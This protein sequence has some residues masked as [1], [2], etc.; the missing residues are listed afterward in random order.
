[1]KIC[2][3]G[4]G[5][6][7]FV[8]ALIL[9]KSYPQFTVDVIRS[10]KIGTIGVGEGSTEHWQAFMD[11]CTITAGELIKETD[12]TFKSGIMFQ[13]W[14]KNDFLQSVHDPFVGEHLGMP[15]MYAK[16]ISNNVHPKEFVGEYTWKSYTPFNKFMDERPNDV[17]VS[18]YHFNT[19]KLNDFLTKKAIEYGCQVIDD[20]IIGI[21]MPDG[22]NITSLKGEK[23]DYHYD[24][25]IDSTGFKRLL[26]D[27]MG[28]KWQSYSKYLKMKEAIVFP[29]E[30]EDEIPIWTVA[31]AMDSGWMFRIPV[32]GRKGNGYIYDSD[33]ISA[34]DAKLEV[35]NYLGHEISVAKNIKFDPGALD[36]P[37]INN[38]CAI[39]LSASFVEP[40]EA[41]SIGTSINQSFLLAQ[42]IVNYNE[43]TTKR[44]NEEVESIMNN[45]RDFIC[46]H[47]VTDKSD[48][49]FWKHITETEMPDS[50]ANNL[51]MWR[52]RLPISDDLTDKTSKILFNEYNYILVMYGLGL[53]DTKAIQK[54]YE[55][56]PPEAKEFV[57]RQM[58]IKKEND[59]LKSIP[60][61][62]ML[63]LIRRLT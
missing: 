34:D 1:M 33:F 20:E 3:V 5:T 54:Q 42:R 17:G 52:T 59:M 28:A 36:K 49:E 43:S 7:G 48:T 24:F 47:Y 46:L 15:L 4:G 31:R 2:V 25:Y 27:K 18:Q 35:E 45:I 19:S 61:K 32:W 14:N 11:F 9:K 21:N 22:K 23:S 60:H 40:L 53:I 37:W 62:V 55:S 13:N 6:A 16:L 41:S 39:G 12:A 8:A 10:T 56:I 38:V 57:N 63:D 58:N 30:E 50:L 29:T 26:I 44:Y 51:E